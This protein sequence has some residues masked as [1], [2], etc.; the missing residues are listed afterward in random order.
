MLSLLPLNILYCVQFF[1]KDDGESGMG[2]LPRLS[3]DCYSITEKV[4]R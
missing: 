4:N 2:L 3:V 1:F